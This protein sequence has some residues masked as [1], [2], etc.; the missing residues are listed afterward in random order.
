MKLYAV[1]NRQ[2]T[3]VRIKPSHPNL[4]NY[5]LNV[6]SG[7]LPP[8]GTSTLEFFSKKNFQIIRQEL[9]MGF[10][11]SHIRIINEK[12]TCELVIGDE[13]MRGEVMNAKRF[14]KTMN[15]LKEL[16]DSIK[17]EEE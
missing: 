5:L 9:K 11:E 8:A 3:R 4:F 1:V 6:R 12:H 2:G 7:I 15:D 16:S 14:V 10:K 17:S 13:S